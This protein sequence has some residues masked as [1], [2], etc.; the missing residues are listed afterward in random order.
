MYLHI[1]SIFLFSMVLGT[2]ES[3]AIP[4]RLHL[5][6]PL[7]AL[8]LTRTIWLSHLPDRAQ[9]TIYSLLN[10]PSSFVRYTPLPGSSG[11]SDFRSDVE[12]GFHS[13]NFNLAEN[14]EGSDSRTGLDAKSKAEVYRI[15]K[16]RGIGFDEARALYTQ[17]SFRKA[18]IGADGL[19]NDPKLVTFGGR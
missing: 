2:G 18:G 6:D 16:S 3:P 19:P 7:P 1:F 17:R 15:M 10:N 12:S 14:I 11:P 8:Y 9:D 5:T 13:S 4:L